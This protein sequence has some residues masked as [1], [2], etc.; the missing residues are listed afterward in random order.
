MEQDCIV[1]YSLE[2]KSDNWTFV[3]YYVT[4]IYFLFFMNIYKRISKD[5]IVEYFSKL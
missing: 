2:S 1:A 3:S 5:S 4:W